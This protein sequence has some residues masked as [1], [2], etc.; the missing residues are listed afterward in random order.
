MITFELPN[1]VNPS[2]SFFCEGHIGSPVIQA[3]DLN[4]IKSV[5]VGMTELNLMLTVLPH[6]RHRLAYRSD[7]PESCQAIQVWYGDT[8]KEIGY[9]WLREYKKWER[10]KRVPNHL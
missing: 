9:Y 6:L 5:E 4:N 3:T 10:N 2:L 7:A 8:A 1:P